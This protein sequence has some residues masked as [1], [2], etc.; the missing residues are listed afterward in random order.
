MANISFDIN[1]LNPRKMGIGRYGFQLVFHL[2]KRKLY[3][4]YALT[5]PKINHEKIG[6]SENNII[7][8]SSINSVFLR[9]HILPVF[10]NLKKIYIIH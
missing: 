1:N 3:N 4:Y 10:Y 6:F 5:S 7:L 8:N 9:S 2:L